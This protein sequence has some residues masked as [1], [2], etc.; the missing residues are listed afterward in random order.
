LYGRATECS[1]SHGGTAIPQP[2]VTEAS[3]DGRV[4]RLAGEEGEGSH[5]AR[6]ATQQRGCQPQ[7][8]DQGPTE[9][10]Y[11]FSL[12]V[13]CYRRECVTP[14]EDPGRDGDPR[15]GKEEGAVMCQLGC[16][17]TVEAELMRRKR[18][19]EGSPETM[20]CEHGGP[21]RGHNFSNADRTNR[22]AQER[23]Q[24]PRAGPPG[25]LLHR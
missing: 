7:R 24:Y 8:I 4:N 22:A 9:R 6:R 12:M 23:V 11:H 16:S 25:K 18:E 15:R 20:K 2:G 1:P 14:G 3:C 10:Y 17:S 21:R 13:L 19:R 5:L